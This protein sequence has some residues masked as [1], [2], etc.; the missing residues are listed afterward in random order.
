ME[1]LCSG[2][3]ARQMRRCGK[4]NCAC[5]SDDAARHGPYY[6]WSR[7]EGGRQVNTTIPKQLVPRFEEALATYREVRVLLKEWERESA[8]LLLET[9]GRKPLDYSNLHRRAKSQKPKKTTRS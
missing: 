3:L 5:A 2:H 6:V 9:E 4:S 8:A 7:R 1:L